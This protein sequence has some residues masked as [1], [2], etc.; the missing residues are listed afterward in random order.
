MKKRFK[1]EKLKL[2]IIEM[3]STLG[4]LILEK[5]LINKSLIMI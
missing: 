5:D 1:V 4:I 2:S 3:E